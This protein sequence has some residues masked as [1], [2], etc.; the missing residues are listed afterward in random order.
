[1]RILLLIIIIS[2]IVSLFS[3]IKYNYSIYNYKINYNNF[4]INKIVI[5]GDS[6]M[7][8]IYDKRN[9]LNIPG[10]FIFD[11]RSGAK[12]DWLKKIGLPKLNNILKNKKTYYKYHVV[13][14]LG[15]NDVDD[16]NLDIE[17]RA[18]DYYK[19]YTNLIKQYEDVN[20]YFL[21]VNPVDE[22]RIYDKF[23][24]YNNRTNK[25][26]EEF[27]NYFIEQLNR[28]NFNNTKYCDSY[29]EL[30]FNLPDG[31]HYDDETDQK[32]IDY[33]NNDCVEFR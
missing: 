11:A 33:I 14:N 1:M 17:K 10:N 27:N 29:N 20:F 2:I 23:S 19:I 13:F 5:V 4:V 6:R 31:L 24:I 8:L 18:S 9:K 16:K 30:I 3:I 7:E 12:I 25:K 21:S 32:I 22:S 26:I 28:D 15:V